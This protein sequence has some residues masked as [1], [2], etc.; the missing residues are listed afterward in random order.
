IYL[1]VTE[2][3][4]DHCEIELHKCEPELLFH[5]CDKKENATAQTM[6]LKGEVCQIS[7]K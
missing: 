4:D 7:P 6:L 2:W 3:E 1:T 5:S